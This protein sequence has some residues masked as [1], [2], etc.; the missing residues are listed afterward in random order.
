MAGCSL[1][2]AFPDITEE[3]GKIARK[4][5]R[6]K[7]KACKGPALAFLQ[8]QEKGPDPDRQAERPPPPPDASLASNDFLQKKALSHGNQK[9][10]YADFKPIRI[11]GSEDDDKALSNSMLGERVND[12]IGQKGRSLPKGTSAIQVTDPGKTMY[13]EPVP[14]YFGKNNDTDSFADFSKLA[15]DNPGYQLEGSDFMTAF[16]GK[17]VDKAAGG[18]GSMTSME[19]DSLDNVWKPLAPRGLVPNAPTASTAA[20]ASTASTANGLA[21]PHDPSFNSE[22][23]QMLLRKLDVLFARLE[24]LESKRNDYAHSEVALF[25]LSGLF[26]MFGMETMRKFR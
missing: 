8:S 7:A 18:A 25:I 15:G 12:V 24:E 21:Y 20:T 23:K 10:S 5:E 19:P 17:G 6:K 22:E 3:S 13:G 9:D 16:S 4:E 14:S 1:T 11:K 26:L 2:E